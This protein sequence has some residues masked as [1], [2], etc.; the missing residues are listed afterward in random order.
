MAGCGL[1]NGFEAGPEGSSSG[2]PPRGRQEDKEA[3]GQ[4]SGPNT[5]KLKCSNSAFVCF[6]YL[7]FELRQHLFVVVFKDFIYLFMRD[8]ER[9]RDTGRGRSR[10]HAGSPMRDSIPGPGSRPEPKADAQ[11][12]SHP[13]VPNENPLRVFFICDCG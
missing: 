8:T 2:S 13:G 12:L 1:G 10:L 11:L 3:R 4:D 9:G 7:H 6:M 5:N